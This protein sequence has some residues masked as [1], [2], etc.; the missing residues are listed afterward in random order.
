MKTCYDGEVIN[1]NVIQVDVNGAC[2]NFDLVSQI[3]T[4]FSVFNF[5][6]KNVRPFEVLE[7][8]LFIYPRRIRDLRVIHHGGQHKC[9][10]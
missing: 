2:L 10:E 8:T 1:Y 4:R 5:C 6:K 3:K 7:D 9:K